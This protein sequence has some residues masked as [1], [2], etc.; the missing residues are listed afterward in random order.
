[1]MNRRAFVEGLCAS[2]AAAG[3]RPPANAEVDGYDGNSIPGL[4]P[5]YPATP[6]PLSPATSASIAGDW[7]IRLDPADTG[8]GDKWFESMD[9]SGDRILLP[10]SAGEHHFGQKNDAVASQHLTPVY[11]FTGP[12][13]YERDITIP[14]SWQGKRVALLLE[15]CH[16][17]TRAWLDGYLLGVRNSLS[18]PHIYEAGFVGA[19]ASHHRS[20]ELLPGSHRLTV[21]VDNRTKVDVGPSSATTAEVG[22]TWNGIVGRMELQVT[23]P[24]WIDR[25]FVYPRFRDKRVVVKLLLRNVTGKKYSGRLEIAGALQDESGSEF[26]A[27]VDV[28]ISDL[29]VSAIEHE[30]DLGAAPPT[31]DEFSP[32]LFQLAVSLSSTGKETKITS[33]AHSTFGMREISASGKQLRWNGNAAVLRGTV[34]NGTFP[35]TGYDPMDVPFWRERLNVYRDYGLNHVRFHSWCPPDAAFTAADQLGM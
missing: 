31:W 33:E 17:E 25:L 5:E 30:I 20:G 18:T 11:T 15:R 28:A 2:V 1:M 21:R 7:R 9:R 35:L 10:G 3:L 34:D 26:M 6:Q 27:A 19:P 8:I 32:A 23:D 13:W 16:W 24:V 4:H 29:P 22:A 12:A 14:D